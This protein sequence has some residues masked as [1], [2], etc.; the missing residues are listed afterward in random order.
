LLPDRVPG[1]GRHV[2]KIRYLV[3]MFNVQAKLESKKFY[4]QANLELYKHLTL[5]LLDDN[6]GLTKKIL[7]ERV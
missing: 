2:H 5:N 6:M 7:F 3:N 1:V 4:H